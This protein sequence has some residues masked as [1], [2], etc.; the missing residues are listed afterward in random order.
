MNKIAIQRRIQYW[1]RLLGFLSFLLFSFRF[2]DILQEDFFK[3]FFPIGIFFSIVAMCLS[4]KIRNRL[5]EYY[6]SPTDVQ[7]LVYDHLELENEHR[8]LIKLISSL[9]V[10]DLLYEIT[11][12]DHCYVSLFKENTE[13]KGIE[14]DA[15]KLQIFVLDPSFLELFKSHMDFQ[16]LIED[17]EGRP[18]LTGSCVTSDLEYYLYEQNMSGVNLPVISEL[19]DFLLSQESDEVAFSFY[20]K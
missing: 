19:M 12:D 1:V 3:W 13:I 16:G 20:K 17:E 2:I 8:R 11:F 15:V 10:D 18:Y 9:K 4:E 5:D 7:D 14:I 6:L